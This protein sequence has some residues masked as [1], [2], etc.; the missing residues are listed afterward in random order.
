MEEIRVLIV[1]DEELVRKSLIRLLPWAE[2]G[3]AV[4]GEAAN[5]RSALDF[6]R[7]REV[8]LI[9]LD[10]AMPI[11]D[12][13]ELL[14]VCEKEF[15]RLVKVVLT[16]YEE[17]EYYRKSMRMGTVD[18]LCKTHFSFEPMDELL[19]FLA[20]KVRQQKQDGCAACYTA[21]DM[22]WL[23]AYLEQRRISYRRLSPLLLLLQ[24]AGDA[25]QLLSDIQSRK[26]LLFHF[27]ET[28]VQTIALH[29]QWIDEYVD[30][31]LFY[32]ASSSPREYDLYGWQ[33]GTELAENDE[34]ELA[35]E[36]T[37]GQWLLYRQQLQALLEKLAK[38]HFSGKRLVSIVGQMSGDLVGLSREAQGEGDP[39]TPACTDYPALQQTMRRLHDAVI[40][41]V[42]NP[43]DGISEQIL[44]AILKAIRLIRNRQ[45][46]TC[47]QEK[48][49]R[50]VGVSRSYFSKC[51]S[52]ITGV[53][54]SAFQRR[55]RILYANDLLESTDMPVY[56]IA[57]ACNF[58][59]ER[60]F[61]RIYY[62][63]M[64]QH[65]MEYRNLIKG[66][67]AAQSPGP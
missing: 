63:Q 5:G 66:Q 20:E 46:I 47:N 35:R 8:D 25:R 48:I 62:E 32:E 65:P 45:Y 16:C 30:R 60:Y 39:S 54:F 44:L 4:V 40:D 9:F 49:A 22:A 31:V 1:D 14:H 33:I 57:Q 52:R 51:F 27:S 58:E 50:M 19:K 64:H 26:I 56:A 15:P 13:F 29:P 23:T 24:D 34:E 2:H 43:S 41:C 42:R 11:M 59:D 55:E 6:L 36:V 18:Y 7:T 10:I 38:H 67:A 3:M 61:A 17:P 12:G 28:D 21:C 53:S 37:D